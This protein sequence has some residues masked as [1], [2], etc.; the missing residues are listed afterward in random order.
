V[1]LVAALVVMLSTPALTHAGQGSPCQALASVV[2]PQRSYA[3]LDI[4][5]FEQRVF[6]YAP[7]IKSG[8]RGGFS[9][10]QL[11]IVEGVYG[12]PFVQ[13]GG[14]MGEPA[15]EQIRNSRNVRATAVPI[16]QNAFETRTFVTIDNR[17]YAL[18]L[19][20]RTSLGGTDRVTVTVCR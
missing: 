2:V 1:T 8:W 4:P 10:F 7:D 5:A 15:F 17:R 19:K 18:E 13:A 6:V 16:E 20:V 14:P 12:R 11:W 9:A 3:R